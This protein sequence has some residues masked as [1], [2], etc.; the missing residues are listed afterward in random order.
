MVSQHAA[1]EDHKD[2]LWKGRSMT[3]CEVIPHKT[4]KWYWGQHGVSGAL[5]KHIQNVYTSKIFAGSNIDR[6]L[7]STHDALK[8]GAI[9]GKIN[10]CFQSDVSEKQ[11]VCKRAKWTPSKRKRTGNSKI[12][13]RLYVVW[14]HK[15]ANCNW[16]ERT[17]S[18]K[19]SNHFP[20]M[21]R[22]S[23]WL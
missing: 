2:D 22:D 23:G 5:T 8:P 14:I 10:G 9:N 20:L 13:F 1:Y 16:W 7:K 3:D 11:R 4:L 18:L 6:D 21:R 15:C 17:I 19:W 12:C